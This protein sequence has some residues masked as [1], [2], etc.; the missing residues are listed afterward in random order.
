[1]NR[2]WAPRA[3]IFILVKQWKFGN[4]SI[5]NNEEQMP[6]SPR[7]DTI[8]NILVPTAIVYGEFLVTTLIGVK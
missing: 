7:D 4:L 8:E 2:F 5:R 6:S 3:R 1:M